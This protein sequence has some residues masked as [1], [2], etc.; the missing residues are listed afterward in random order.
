MPNSSYVFPRVRLAAVD[1]VQHAL[2]LGLIREILHDDD[3]S[4]TD[5]TYE[6]FHQHRP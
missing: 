3:R 4:M 6:I 5:M 1:H 2:A